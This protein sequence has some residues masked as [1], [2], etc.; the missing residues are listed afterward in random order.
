MDIE[1]DLEPETEVLARFHFHLR[2]I[3]GR[4]KSRLETS[5]REDTA[6][7]SF[8]MKVAHWRNL[9]TSTSTTWKK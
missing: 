3:P 2:K 8:C 6:A 1:R 9:E 4:R 7:H 5:L